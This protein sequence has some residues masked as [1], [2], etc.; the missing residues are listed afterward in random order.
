MYAVQTKVFVYGFW[1]LL[2]ACLLGASI[3]A[4]RI[5]AE[6]GRF[7]AAEKRRRELWGS[8]GSGLLTGTVVSSALFGLQ[9][10]S[11]IDQRHEDRTQRESDARQ[12]LLLSLNMGPDL[13]GLDATTLDEL[14]ES[15]LNDGGDRN[16]SN[17]LGEGTASSRDVCDTE[18]PPTRRPESALLTDIRLTGKTLDYANFSGLTLR[19]IDLSN[20]SLRH[21]T[22]CHT[23]LEDVTL[24]SADLTDATFEHATLRDVDLQFAKLEGAEVYGPTYE[25]TVVNAETCWPNRLGSGFQQ[26]GVTPAAIANRLAPVR[27]E[28]KGH[29]CRPD[30]AEQYRA[31]DRTWFAES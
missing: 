27:E 28:S 4:L 22:F 18:K 1:V 16:V 11:D 14:V 12:A 20:A 24:T 5:A 19:G 30:E 31:G 21:A 6:K 10:I 7:G 26:L 17:V 13:R 9:L 2:T 15:A 25:R 29:T 3:L 8:V 23:A